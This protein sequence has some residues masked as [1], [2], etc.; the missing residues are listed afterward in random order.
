MKGYVAKKGLQ[1]YA[2]I[3]EGRDPLTGRER[4]RWH[5]AGTDERAARELAREIAASQAND[6]PR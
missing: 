6:H 3:Y 2:V 1:F 4:R 5:P